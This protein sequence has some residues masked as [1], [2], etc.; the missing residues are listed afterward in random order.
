[1]DTRYPN[2][3]SFMGPEYES[4]TDSAIEAAFESAFG[5]G[6]TPAEYESFFGSIGNAFKDAGRFVQKEAPGLTNIAQGAAQGAAA[7]SSLGIYGALGG[8]LVGA[9]GAGLRHYGTGTTKDVGGALGS[10]VGIAGQLTGRGATAQ[11]AGSLVGMGG[12]ALQGKYPAA[13]QL[14]SLLSRPEVL[15]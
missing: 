8:A 13:G 14:A 2:L 6:V 5:E 15:A 11:A 1:M 4:L 7:G 10:V 3:R 12:G 9:T